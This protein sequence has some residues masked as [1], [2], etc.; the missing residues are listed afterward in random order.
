MS[1]LRHTFKGYLYQNLATAVQLAQSLL[2]EADRI[3]I[4]KKLSDPDIFDDLT[5]ITSSKTVRR[6]FK[7]TNKTARPFL[8]EDLRTT[9]SG[10]RI[11]ALC[12][13][14]C[15]GGT[16]P[17]IEYRVCACWTEPEDS[18]LKD[19][20]VIADG[21]C[22]F[23]N[24]KTTLFKI[25]LEKLWPVNGEPIWDIVSD[26]G[27]S[28]EDYRQ[29]CSRTLLEVNC[30]PMSADLRVPGIAEAG[31]I[32]LLIDEVGV[33]R[34]PNEHISPVD[35]AARLIYEAAAHRA[36]QLTQLINGYPKRRL[37]VSNKSL[38][39]SEHT[40]ASAETAAATS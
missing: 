8:A 1:D 16:T 9:Q 11:D 31:L 2:G 14:I 33:G 38:R 26:G 28:R 10:I 27:L 18:E 6:Q 21:S 13:S 7:H 22:T 23:P 30:P 32:T 29:L 39:Q 24:Y 20:L 40:P 15:A 17:P 37:F 35:A 25:D 5:V 36:P 19:I 34:F 4:D 12:R 3:V